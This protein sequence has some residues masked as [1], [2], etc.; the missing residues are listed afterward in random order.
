MRTVTKKKSKIKLVV[1]YLWIA[2]V[3]YTWTESFHSAQ[4]NFKFLKIIK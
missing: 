2:S 1:K 3:S 4:I